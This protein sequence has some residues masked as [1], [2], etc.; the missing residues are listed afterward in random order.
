MNHWALTPRIP[1]GEGRSARTLHAFF[2]RLGPDGCA[3]IA[4]VTADLAASYQQAARARVPHTRMVFDRFHVE[5]LA[6]DALDEVRRAGQRGAD[7]GGREGAQGDALSVAEA[8]GAP[9]TG[10]GPRSRDASPT[11]SGAEPRLR[12]EGVPG[13]DPGTGPGRGGAGVAGRVGGL[14]GPLTSEALHP[15]RSDHPQARRRHWTRA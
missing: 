11:A 9:G 12:A 2:D 6:T 5:R 13:N 1:A 14:G 15:G 7:P 10:R 8:P 4:L 3:R